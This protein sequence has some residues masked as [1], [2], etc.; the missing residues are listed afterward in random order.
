MSRTLS[1]TEF[2]IMC[3]FWEVFEEGEKGFADIMTYFRTTQGR[4]WSKQ[5]L[6]IFL[7][8]LIDKGLLQ[9]RKVGNRKYYIAKMTRPEYDQLCAKEALRKSFDGNL[10]KFLAALTGEE[11]ISEVDEQELLDYIRNK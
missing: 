4:E 7:L 8:R 6:N 5:T 9:F 2:D 1:A 11:K 10:P 3:Y